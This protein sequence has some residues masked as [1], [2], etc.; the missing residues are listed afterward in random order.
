MSGSGSATAEREPPLRFDASDWAY[1]ALLLGVALALRVVVVSIFDVPATWDGQFYHRGAVSIAEGFGYSEPGLVRGVPGRLPWSHYPVGYSALLGAAY[2]L[3]GSGIHVAPLVNAVV[4]GLT[5]VL[6]FAFA[7]T[8]TTRTRACV[9]GALVAVHPGL[10]L[11]CALVMTEPLA[12]FLVLLTGFLARALGRRRIGVALTGVALAASV[13]VRPQSL[14]Y[15]PLLVLLFPGA[16]AARLA[17][18]AAAGAVALL[19]IAPW[20]V[21]NCVRLDGCAAISTNGGWNLAIGALSETGRF[22][23]L[24][25]AD[26]CAGID[27]PVEQ[28]RCWAE[29]GAAAIQ[30]DPAAW[31]G[32]IPDKLRHTYN[33]ESFA[34]AYLAEA[35]PAAWSEPF[36]WRVM[37]VM[38]SI[39]HI[40]MFAAALGAVGRFS[41]QR[42]RQEWPQPLIVLGLLAFAAYALTLPDRPVFW[43]GVI[44]PVLG[45]ARLPGAPPLSGPFAYLYGLLAITSLTHMIFFGDD[46]YHLTISPALCLLAAAAFRAPQRAEQR[47]SASA[48]LTPQAPALPAK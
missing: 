47:S 7:R 36:K 23:P 11:Y 15:A 16:L 41:L 3:F 46:R 48:T 12:G 28:D 8:L 30:R 22:R 4:G 21:R 43:I 9:A 10:T 33:H 37:N 5:A 13:F 31:L 25:D 44:I 1:C 38:T 39:H 2:A 24:T 45:L 19:C 17:R 6:T 14:L 32:R 34:I 27:G 42:W 35:E 20:T 29:I 18:T 26:G 40:L